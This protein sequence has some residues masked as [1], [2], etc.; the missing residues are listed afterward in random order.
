MNGG[1]TRQRRDRSIQL[2]RRRAKSGE[3]G[4]ADLLEWSA[5]SGDRR[6]KVGATLPWA[7]HGELRDGGHGV[8]GLGYLRSNRLIERE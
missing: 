2:D 8:G 4:S 5:R 1:G 6:E 3:T 7:F